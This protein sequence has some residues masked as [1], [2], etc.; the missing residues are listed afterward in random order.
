MNFEPEFKEGNGK[1]SECVS[2]GIVWPPN[3]IC[4]QCFGST[5]W[6]NIYPIGKLLEFSK[7]EEG[8]FGLAEFEEKIRIIGKINS[9]DQLPKVG[10]TV[11]LVNYFKDGCFHFD[12]CLI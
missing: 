10:Q 4:N 3:E 6:R 8:F 5:I 12:L 9:K 11:K 2:C 7:N 1:V